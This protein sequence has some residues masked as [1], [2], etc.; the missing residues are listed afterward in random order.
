MDYHI[1]DACQS[2]RAVIGSVLAHPD[3]VF[4][5]MSTLAAS[6]FTMPHRLIFEACVQIA[7]DG[8]LPEI[9]PL[10]TI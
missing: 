4:E 8:G 1:E 7:N 6:D 10:L 3:A 5:V 2:E 9:P